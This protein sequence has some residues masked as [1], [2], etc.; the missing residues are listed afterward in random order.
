M[1]RHNS[2]EM[3]MMN[4]AYG[5]DKDAKEAHVK[6]NSVCTWFWVPKQ[7]KANSHMSLLGAGRNHYSTSGFYE[8]L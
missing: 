4:S 2:D 5:E 8:N 6:V 3:M 1:W 7:Y